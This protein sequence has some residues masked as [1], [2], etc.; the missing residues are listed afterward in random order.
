MGMKN[1]SLVTIAGRQIRLIKKRHP[2]QSFLGLVSKNT[3]GVWYE[4]VRNSSKNPKCPRCGRGRKI[5]S[6]NKGS[7]KNKTD[8][9]VYKSGTFM[10]KGDR[11]KIQRFFCVACKLTFSSSS[12]SLLR[13]IKKRQYFEQIFL[14]LTS[15]TSMRRTA[16]ELCI[17]RNTLS[18]LLPVMGRVARRE[19]E[20]WLKSKSK[21]S[22]VQ[23]DELITFESSR[24]KPVAVAVVVDSLSMEVLSFS[25]AK[26]SP[27]FKQSKVAQ[28]IYGTRTDQK[29]RGLVQSLKS[30]APIMSND[31]VVSS[32]QC[33]MYSGV[34]Q[35]VFSGY[36]L[37]YRQFK[38][39]RAR[40]VG[41]G[42]MKTGGYDPLFSINH[43]LAMF[44]SNVSRLQRRTW[45]TTKKRSRL[46]YHL[47]I[48]VRFLNMVLIPLRQK[49]NGF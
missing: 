5:S 31:C 15:G 12:D 36:S 7:E 19:H 49:T 45:N 2:N 10:R 8:C 32:D 17:S 16:R 48:M 21:V 39:R 24:C 44:R 22:D 9:P 42:E 37:I 41:F 28:K 14:R 6:F 3:P 38:S 11:A 25:V 23:F 13:N 4:R 33:P 40:T 29:K 34:M 30:A 35:S 47:S 20:Q 46:Y 18:L 43:T 26:A 27:H 1:D